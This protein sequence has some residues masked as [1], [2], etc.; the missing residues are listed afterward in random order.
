MSLAK[1]VPANVHALLADYGAAALLLL[2]VLLADDPSTA[3]RNVGLIMGVGLLLGS[4]FTAYPLGVVRVIPFRLHSAADY[5]GALVLIL[6]P[7][8]FGFYDTDKGLATFY[9]VLG[10]A[11]VALSLITDYDDPA[12]QATRTGATVAGQR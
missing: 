2:A 9:I 12:A 5:L 6:A 10:V 1:I 3:A 7:F 4:L 11:D 8:V